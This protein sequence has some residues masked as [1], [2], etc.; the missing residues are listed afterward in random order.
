MPPTKS[1][2]VCANILG[3]HHE[4]QTVF[5]V[6]T[7]KSGQNELYKTMMLLDLHQQTGEHSGLLGISVQ[8]DGGAAI[9]WRRAYKQQPVYGVWWGT[10]KGAVQIAW[11]GEH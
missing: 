3:G 2:S 11:V 8:E 1:W 7:A 10:R 4:I 5:G 9:E 6:P